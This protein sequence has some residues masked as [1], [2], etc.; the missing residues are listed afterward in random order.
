MGNQGDAWIF[1][2]D[3]PGLKAEVIERFCIEQIDYIGE[4]QCPAVVL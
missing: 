2:F 1:A 4:K 3:T